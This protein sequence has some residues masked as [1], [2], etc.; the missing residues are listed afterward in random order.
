MTTKCRFDVDIK[1]SVD[2]TKW[3]LKYYAGGSQ[4]SS[5]APQP[6]GKLK[7]GVGVLG[8]SAPCQSWS[9]QMSKCPT[10]YDTP[11]RCQ[12]HQHFMSSFCAKI[13]SPKKYKPKL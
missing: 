7:R 5:L 9:C 8:A 4:D 10:G 2:P 1:R 12:F 13:L 11:T 3:I 6:S